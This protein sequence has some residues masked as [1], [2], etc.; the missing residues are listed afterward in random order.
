[1]QCDKKL[2]Q[3]QVSP[4]VIDSLS[5]CLDPQVKIILIARPLLTPV[6]QK[7][8][9]VRILY[10]H[11]RNAFSFCDVASKSLLL[12]A[13]L[14]TMCILARK[15]TNCT[16]RWLVTKFRDTGIVCPWQMLFEARKSEITV[17][18]MS[19]SR[20]AEGTGYGCEDPTWTLVWLLCAWKN[21]HVV[22]RVRF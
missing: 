20:L 1:M 17:V 21:S 19:S 18:P 12:F 16:V 7:R 8:V 11:E 5:I 9:N 10:I 22:V 4:H 14:L 2:I 3:K 6:V 13:E 15:Y